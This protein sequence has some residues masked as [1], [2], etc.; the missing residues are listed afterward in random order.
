MSVFD[1]ELMTVS[2]RVGGFSQWEGIRNFAVGEFFLPDGGNL[3]R[4]NFDHLNLFQS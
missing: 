1:V 4:S 2:L 3:Q